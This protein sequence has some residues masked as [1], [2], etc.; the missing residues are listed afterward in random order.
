MRQPHLQS[1]LSFRLMCLEFRIRDLVSPPEQLLREAGV[2][3]GMTVLDFGCGPGGY[4]IAA[5]RLVGRQGQVYAL[6][7]HPLARQ[8]VSRAVTRKDLPQVRVLDGGE[9]KRIPDSSVD[10]VMLYDVLH[11]IPAPAGIL[12]EFRRILGERGLLSV[13][14]HHLKEASILETVASDKR[15]RFA[16]R[17]HHAVRFEPVIA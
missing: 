5:A 4:T 14:D 8:S 1:T 9:L 10:M 3:S 11:E 17:D 7:I 16:G 6:D 15:F 13:N 2:I 12:D